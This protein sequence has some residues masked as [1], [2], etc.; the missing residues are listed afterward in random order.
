MRMNVPV[1]VLATGLLAS[2]Q[3]ACAQA[4][5]PLTTRLGGAQEA[6]P[7]SCAASQS[8]SDAWW[9]G[10]MLAN[11]AATLPRGHFLL[12]PY[13]YD[14]TAASRYDGSGTRHRVARSNSYGS[15]TYAIYGVTDRLAL[16]L[17]PTAGFNTA[18]DGPSSSGIG[19]GDVALHAQLGLTQFRACHRTPALSIAVQETFPTGKYDRL[20]NRPSNALGAGAYT[21]TLALYSQTYFLLPTGRMLRMRF[22]ASQAFSSSVGVQDVSVY[23][24]PTGFRGHAR[25]GLS[26]FVDAAWEYSLTRRWV[27]ALDA[28]YRHERNTLVV[29]DDAAEAISGPNPTAILLSSGASDAFA[30]APAIEYSWRSTIGVLLGGRIIAAGRNI[31]ATITP[32]VAINIV[33]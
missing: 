21:T 11:S 14:V 17:I 24:T 15:L 16:G 1:A 23:G 30:L 25:P 27:L 20:G 29:G 18:S 12:E 3:A 31:A 28:T 5:L 9:T 32:A 7:R 10:P 26:T 19:L 13:V 22:N 4:A 8:L 2:S 33:R 6:G